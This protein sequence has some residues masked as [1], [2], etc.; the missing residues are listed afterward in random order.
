LNRVATKIPVLR[1]CRSHTRPLLT[2]RRKGAAKFFG[3]RREAK[4]HAAFAR[5]SVA[6]T[7]GDGLAPE[8]GVAAVLCHRS[9]KSARRVTGLRDG[10]AKIEPNPYSSVL[11][12]LLRVEAE[13]PAK[14]LQ[15]KLFLRHVENI[16]CRRQ[17][18]RNGFGQ[19]QIDRP[20]FAGGH[21]D[22]CPRTTRHEPRRVGGPALGCS[23]FFFLISFF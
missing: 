13:H 17:P 5:S 6:R 9:P 3:L 23:F 2:Q 1:T 4:R 20:H 19:H 7:H 16:S 8:S 18:G 10:S 11:A 22:A 21:A 15:Q 14:L 12:E